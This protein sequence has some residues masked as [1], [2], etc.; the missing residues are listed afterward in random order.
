M[1]LCIGVR[2]AVS[3]LDQL[4][5]DLLARRVP[6]HL[7]RVVRRLAASAAVTAEPCP[8]RTRSPRRRLASRD[9][10]G[11]HIPRALPNRP[12][13][14]PSLGQLESLQRRPV[15]ELLKLVEREAELA[16]AGEFPVRDPARPR[17]P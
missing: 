14:A 11:R 5:L 8:M 1:R 3:E 12:A 13:Y 15:L 4:L 9:D 7:G 2:S 10:G 17:P 16:A 6:G